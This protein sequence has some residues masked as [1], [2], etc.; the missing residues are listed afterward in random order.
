MDVAGAAGIDEGFF[1]AEEVFADGGGEKA[2]EA[3]KVGVAFVDVVGPRVET[4]SVVVDLPDFDLSVADIEDASAEVGDHADG[5]GEGE[6]L[7]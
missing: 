6:L 2:A 1:G 3:L 5:G 4:G 7:G